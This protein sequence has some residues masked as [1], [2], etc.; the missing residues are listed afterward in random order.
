MNPGVDNVIE[1]CHNAGMKSPLRPLSGDVFLGAAKLLWRKLALGLYDF[2]KRRLA[3]QA[4]ACSGTNR[5]ERRHGL[6]FRNAIFGKQNVIKPEI[7]Y[8]V[9]SCLVDALDN[10]NR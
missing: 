6:A 10:G 5:R 8:E 4:A 2:P 1:L 9:H 7:A 3:T